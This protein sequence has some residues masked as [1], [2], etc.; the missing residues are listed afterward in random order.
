[1]AITDCEL[2]SKA[3]GPLPIINDVLSRLRLLEFVEMRVPHDDQRRKLAPASTLGVLLRNI[4][5]AREPLYGLS[6]WAVRF[7]EQSL[8]L[9]PRGG[10]LINDDRAGRCLDLLFQADRGALLTDI[11]V[12][13]VRTF[14]L[15]LSEL[16]NDSTTVSLSGQYPHA[17]GSPY[18]GRPTLRIAFGHNKDHRPDLK[19]LLFI[20]TTAGDG[21][22]PV[23]CS[24]EHGN[25]SDD[26]TH[27]N[28]W[29]TLCRLVG[30]VDFLY[31]ADSKLC[32]MDNMLHIARNGGRF[33][34]V[35]PRTRREDTWFRNWV[36]TNN[37]KWVELLRK[38]NSRRKSG[39]DEVFRGFESPLPSVEGFRIAWIW[40]SQKFE[41]DRTIRENSIE[42]AVQEL[43]HLRARIGSPKSQ[44]K[45]RQKIENAAAEILTRCNAKRWIATKVSTTETQRFSQARPGRPSTNTQYVR[46]T[47]MAFQ[48]SWVAVDEALQYDSR[49]D[50][51]FPLIFND[52]K[53][54]LSDALLAYKRQ[55]FLEKRHEQMKTAF[56]VMP[57]NLKTPRR[58]EALLF[59]YF[60]ALLVESLIEREMRLAMK[61]AEIESIPL[62][63]ESR[64]CKAPTA[65]RIFEVFSDVRRHRLL[66]PNGEVHKCFHDK[67]TDIQSTLLQLLGLAPE[68]YFSGGVGARLGNK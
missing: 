25:T 60:L 67:L 10:D 53:L 27:V 64:P 2:L 14:D 35:L 37:P 1:L 44:L 5:V 63:P 55:P 62:Y 48:L 4:L 31:V 50:G 16:H 6:E 38:K 18:K 32:T 36:Q 42:R 68:S 45:T 34:T 66:G 9:P 54:E 22:V 19:Q 61:A 13:A 20:L 17:D 30:G 43:E 21:A 15:D 56:E 47:K 8:G 24:A 59:V 11:M 40:S 41:L 7:D 58:I 65:N 28:T 51:L 39:P 23:W 46:K 52:K 3:L 57:V 33:V 26:H 49:L 29:N 12:H